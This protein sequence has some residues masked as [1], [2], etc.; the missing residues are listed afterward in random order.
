M[1]GSASYVVQSQIDGGT[2]YPFYN[3]SQDG[4]GSLGW[5]PNTSS[6]QWIGLSSIYSNCWVPSVAGSNY[7]NSGDSSL[8]SPDDY[9]GYITFQTSFSVQNAIDV[10]SITANLWADNYVAAIY[11]NGTDV[12]NASGPSDLGFETANGIWP[13]L[14]GLDLLAGPNYLDIVTYN[15][16]GPAGLCANFDVLASPEPAS[17]LLLGGGLVLLAAFR[18]RK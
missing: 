9:T 7:C 2:A 10:A 14:P 18:R 4:V 12:F 5:T 3:P 15:E 6:E 16:G 17:L 8:V 11:L 13:S 1:S